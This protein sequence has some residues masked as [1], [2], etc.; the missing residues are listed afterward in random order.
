MLSGLSEVALVVFFLAF[1]KALLAVF[2]YLEALLLIRLFLKDSNEFIFLF[3]T[4]FLVSGMQLVDLRL[5]AAMLLVESF[6]FAPKRFI[7]A[8]QVLDLLKLVLV[9][10][11]A[12]FKECGEDDKFLE[13]A[14]DSLVNL[15][16]HRKLL[17][18]L[19]HLAALFL[20]F[21][22]GSAQS[23]NNLHP[24]RSWRHL[25]LSSCVALRIAGRC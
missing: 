17:L 7:P 12:F 25:G 4:S 22:P 20:D 3:L 9:L 18:L 13:F 11:T 10:L 8:K 16:E 14:F 24:L 5:L 15:L 6:V 21:L 23:L 2:L 19:L 1:D